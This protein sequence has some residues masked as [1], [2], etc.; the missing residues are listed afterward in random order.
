MKKL[1]III[2]IGIASN[3]AVQ[4]STSI[5]TFSTAMASPVFEDWTKAEGGTWAGKDMVWYKLDKDAN[6][7]WSKDGKKWEKSPDGTWQ[8]KDGKWLKIGDKKLWW[9]TDGKEWKEVPE[10]KWQ[11]TDGKW[12]KFDSNWTVWV[13]KG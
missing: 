13:N 7:W 2:G 6:L 5:T 4:A 12:Y 8:D 11:G 9:S 3:F 10:W 1:V